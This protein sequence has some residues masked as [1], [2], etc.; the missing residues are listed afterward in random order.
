MTL[1]NFPV[2][3]FGAKLP[4]GT[5]SHAFA[6]NGNASNPECAGVDGILGAYKQ[7]LSSVTVRIAHLF[8]H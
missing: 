2:Y 4:N 6:L 5:V 7:A 3:G 8:V 1:Q